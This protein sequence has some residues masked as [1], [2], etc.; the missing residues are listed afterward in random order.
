MNQPYPGRL[1][2]ILCAGLALLSLSLAAQAAQPDSAHHTFWSVKGA[3]NTVYLLGSVHM[4]QPNA[5][6]LPP[7]A[8]RAYAN[9]KA[10]VMEL[11]LNQVSADD[12]LGAGLALSTLPEGQSL[13][14]VLGPAA[15]AMLAKHAQ[16]LGLDLAL[17]S[18]FQPWFAAVTVEQLEL[19]RLGF[20][21]NAGV[22]MQFAQRAQADHKQIIALETVEQQLGLFAH[23]SLDQQRQFLLYTLE[24]DDKA[25]QSVGELVT[26]WRTGDT[27]TLERL[28]R[29]DA[30]EFPA[31]H[32]R[33]TTDRNR[34][35]LATISDLLRD[36]QDYLVIVGALHLVGRDGVVEL[37][38]RAG[39][40][41]VQ[42]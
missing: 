32:Q 6:D 29:E 40:T 25:P 22:D 33:L 16:P 18:R 2:S 13:E 34:K 41:A 26:A 7:D 21:A 3:H 23:L 20:D 14:R 24:D 12:L 11:D 4:L 42:H 30:A 15:Y 1:R 8:L 5:S 31:L 35:W 17:L 37:L 9:A 10:L 39:Y 36:N 19:A 28:L 38:G 27:P